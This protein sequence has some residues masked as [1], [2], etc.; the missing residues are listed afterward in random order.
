MGAIPPPL[1][2]AVVISRFVYITIRF[3]GGDER[4]KAFLSCVFAGGSSSTPRP[5]DEGFG[6]LRSGTGALTHHE[7]LFILLIFLSSA[8]RFVSKLAPIMIAVLVRKALDHLI[9]GFEALEFV[10]HLLV[11][12]CEDDFL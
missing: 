9:G 8:L 1:V 6:S 5:P 12:R 3:S 2:P 7:L 4:T 11:L 10:V